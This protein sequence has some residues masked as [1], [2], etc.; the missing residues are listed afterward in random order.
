MASPLSHKLFQVLQIKK[1]CSTIAQS[2][3]NSLENTFYGITE[4]ETGRTRNQNHA[5]Q[6]WG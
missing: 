5:K 2:D 6:G 4:S 1:H 3:S